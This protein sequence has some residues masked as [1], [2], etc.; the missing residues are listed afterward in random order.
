MEASLKHVFG[1]RES[2]GISLLAERLHLLAKDSSRGAR[3]HD[4]RFNTDEANY[5]SLQKL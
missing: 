4:V 1:F 2:G 3:Q 5:G